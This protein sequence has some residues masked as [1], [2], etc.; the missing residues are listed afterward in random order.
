MVTKLKKRTSVSRHSNTCFNIQCHQNT[1]TQYQCLL[2][3]LGW[4]AWKWNMIH[5]NCLHHT[6]LHCL[7]CVN[8][9]KMESSIFRR[10]HT[11]VKIHWWKFES[12]QQALN[13]ILDNCS[14]FFTM[15]DSWS[16][17]TVVR[18]VIEKSDL[19]MK[20]ALS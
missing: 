11:N 20:T 4:H 19:L 16:V 17:S 7:V 9:V 14:L 1:P 2:T 12:R 18:I 5:V 15:N 8:I 13:F 10:R 6:P 3:H